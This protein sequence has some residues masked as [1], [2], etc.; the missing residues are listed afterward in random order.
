V[1]ARTSDF[2]G[3]VPV[4]AASAFH[5][6]LVNKM[7]RMW[8]RSERG[9][10]LGH[11]LKGLVAPQTCFA[12]DRGLFPFAMAAGTFDSVRLVT[13]GGGGFCG[14]GKDG[15]GKDNHEEQRLEIFQ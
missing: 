6:V 7:V 11:F 5:V 13:V 2:V 12:G 9:R 3:T 8:V 14:L 10:A 15:S 1:A 4:M